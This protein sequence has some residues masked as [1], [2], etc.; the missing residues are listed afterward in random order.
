MKKWINHDGSSTGSTF[1]SIIGTFFLPNGL[2]GKT[3]RWKYVM[4]TL[5]DVINKEFDVR[6]KRTQ[7]R[8]SKYT[9]KYQ[10]RKPNYT[11]KR[12]RHA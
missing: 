6:I 5:C 12:R 11:K 2:N 8:V 9:Q 7:S 10:Q 3:F 4:D 1:F